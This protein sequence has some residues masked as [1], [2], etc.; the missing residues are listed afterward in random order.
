MILQQP[1][2]RVQAAASPGREERRKSWRSEPA[3]QNRFRLAMLQLV[4]VALAPATVISLVVT[5]SVQHPETFLDSPWVPLATLAMTVAAGA[6]ILRECDR[7]SSRFCGPT[8]RIIQ[9]LQAVRRGERVGP[10][11]T[12]AGDEF[13]ELARELSET[14]VKLGVMDDDA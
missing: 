1:A 13:A 7:L 5:H 4:L 12:R 3:F 9:A 8:F 14:L 10:V 2:D 6:L 11:R